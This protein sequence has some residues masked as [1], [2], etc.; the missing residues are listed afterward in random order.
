MG[1][2][3]QSWFKP[4]VILHWFHILLSL[5]MGSTL[6]IDIGKCL[7]SVLRV[8]LLRS[9]N[10]IRKAVCGKRA[11]QPL[12]TFSECARTRGILPAPRSA[13]NFPRPD[14]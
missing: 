11:I 2:T 1:S 3:L 5:L 8:V 9:E 4:A 14:E 6:L 12:A 13:F 10:R 7:T